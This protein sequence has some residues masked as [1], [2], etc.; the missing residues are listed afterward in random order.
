MFIPKLNEKRCP[1]CGMFVVKIADTNYFRCQMVNCF[2]SK[3]KLEWDW[4]YGWLIVPEK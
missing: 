2:L 3:Q 4:R 1:N